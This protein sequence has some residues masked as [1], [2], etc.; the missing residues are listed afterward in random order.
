MLL[1]PVFIRHHRQIGPQSAMI[2]PCRE[3]AALRLPSCPCAAGPVNGA[4]AEHLVD[5]VQHWRPFLRPGMVIALDMLSSHIGR[6]FI[7][8]LLRLQVVVAPWPA[9]ATSAASAFTLIP[10]AD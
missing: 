8:A 6:P 2:C 5:A 9:G 7:E 1:P 10:C 3:G 4:H